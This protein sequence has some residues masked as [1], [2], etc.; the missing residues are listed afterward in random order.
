MDM[1]YKWQKNAPKLNR[2]KKMCSFIEANKNALMEP[3]EPEKQEKTKE[4]EKTQEPQEVDAR[5]ILMKSIFKRKNIDFN[6]NYMDMYYK[7]EKDAPKV[8]RYKKMCTFVET[9]G[10]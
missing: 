5:K 8:N 3:Q 6:D 4:P 2:Y 10:F 7:W 1:Y 9:Q